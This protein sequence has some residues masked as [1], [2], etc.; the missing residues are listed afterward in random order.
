VP[1]LKG[2]AAATSKSGLAH[3]KKKAADQQA[4]EWFGHGISL[5]NMNQ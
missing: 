1:A 3:S 5:N 4:C 2:A